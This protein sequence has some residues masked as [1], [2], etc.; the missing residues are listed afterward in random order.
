MS[1]SGL[2]PLLIVVQEIRRA[3]RVEQLA[4]NDGFDA[5]VSAERGD[6]IE[7]VA[8]LACAVRAVPRPV[9]ATFEVA[10]HDLV[11]PQVTAPAVQ[12][13][14]PRELLERRIF[15]RDLVRNT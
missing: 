6:L 5:A 14:N 10:D 8:R 11:V 3:G 1:S 15:D 9:V 12:L 4:R 2:S 7:Q 13:E